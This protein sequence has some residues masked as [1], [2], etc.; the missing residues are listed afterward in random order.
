MMYLLLALS[1]VLAVVKSGIYN[2]YAKNE[3]PGMNS[4]FKF[5]AI[6]YGIA[7]IVALCFGI[8]KSLST[9]TLLLSICYAVVVCLLQALSVL[10]MKMGSLSATSLMSLYGMIIPSVAGPIFWKE[11]FGII[12]AIGVVLVL[13]SMW[14]LRKEETHNKTV[15]KKWGVIVTI[16]FILS[17]LAG[18]IE[19]IHQSTDGRG[20]KTMF[21]FV[22]YIIMFLISVFGLLFSKK[23]SGKA[24]SLRS[25]AL[26][27]GI[28][29]IIIGFYAF[30]N[31][32]L[33]GNLDS[34][35]Y[36]PVANGGALL[37][38]VLLSI[39]IFHEKCTKRHI[40]G[41]IIGFLSIILLSL[42]I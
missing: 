19:K 30:I 23:Q 36:Y 18:L 20:E 31:L 28:S 1:I 21:L 14:L 17:G 41:F 27:G 12:Q 40:E 22:A 38:T 33:A 42:P 32:T 8:G 6:S 39:T 16:V 11:K 35:I 4:I 26:N 29:G 34:M 10:A 7:G 37:L 9:A 15:D 2:N 3:K 24:N 13:V 5:N 25:V